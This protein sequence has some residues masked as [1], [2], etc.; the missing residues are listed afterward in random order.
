MRKIFLY[1]LL[2]CP[3]SMDAQLP[4]DTLKS[5]C[6]ELYETQLNNT[7]TLNTPLADPTY[8]IEPVEEI[9]HGYFN[10]VKVFRVNCHHFTLINGVPTATMHDAHSNQL[11]A[12]D[13]ITGQ[14]IEINSIE[15]FNRIFAAS[16]TL[17]NLDKCYLYLLLATKAPG[18]LVNPGKYRKALSN[19]SVFIRDTIPHYTN[20]SYGVLYNRNELDRHL[21]I[22]SQ[23]DRDINQ[24][25]KNNIYI[26]S[27]SEKGTY[28]YEFIYTKKG[29]LKEVKKAELKL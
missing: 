10:N 22:N 7:S 16:P 9:F 6:K 25:T 13:P 24:S 20:H 28:R 11:Y 21:M 26:Y 18:N 23:I 29:A 3:L 2:F 1:M 4:D 8:R 14:E 15:E 17:C 12:L 19:A 27:V 5:I